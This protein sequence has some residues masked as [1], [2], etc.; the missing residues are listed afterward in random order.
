MDIEN[1]FG[2]I[3]VEDVR[4]IMADDEVTVS[5]IA[6]NENDSK[7]LV[8]FY[9]KYNNNFCI[10]FLDDIKMIPYFVSSKFE[11][12]CDKYNLSSL[13]NFPYNNERAEKVV[14]KLWNSSFKN[15]A[16]AQF[17]KRVVKGITNI[18]KGDYLEAIKVMNF[19][20]KEVGVEIV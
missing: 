20:L 9:R 18:T 4:K 15:S 16:I 11:E 7:I 6:T 13:T 19:V 17:Q 14:L 5:K 2:L 10:L 3:D 12:I 1:S 8:N